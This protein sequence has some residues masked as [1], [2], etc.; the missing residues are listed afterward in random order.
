MKIIGKRCPC[1]CGGILK[2]LGS[3]QRTI[4][5]P[6]GNKIIVYIVRVIC[7]CCGIS[8][9]L[10]PSFIVPYKQLNIFTIID[11]I[12]DIHLENKSM[13][14]LFLCYSFLSYTSI[15]KLY[16]LF[17]DKFLHFILMAHSTSTLNDDHFESIHNII[18][19]YLNVAFMQS[20]KL[21]TYYKF[22]I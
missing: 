18:S 9:A 2:E 8:H 5:C 16:K 15:Y 10:I 17:I 6:F 22:K 21:C 11:I 12:K 1:G 3:Y 4:I 13:Y 7:D 14:N 20:H 19:D